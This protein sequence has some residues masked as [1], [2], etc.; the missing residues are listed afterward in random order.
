MAPN[1]TA[2]K[3]GSHADDADHIVFELDELSLDELETLEEITGLPFDEVIQEGKPKAAVMK[4]FAY[5]VKKRTDP[6]FTIEQ[7]G[8]L[9]IRFAKPDPTRAAGKS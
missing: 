8:A 9:K 1:R 4:A 6:D 3:N 5:I 7:A 2:V